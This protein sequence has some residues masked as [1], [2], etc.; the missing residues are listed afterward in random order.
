MGIHNAGG[1]GVSGGSGG[2]DSSF[3]VTRGSMM[4]ASDVVCA[5]QWLLQR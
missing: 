5:G 1:F 4:C 3:S 2:T